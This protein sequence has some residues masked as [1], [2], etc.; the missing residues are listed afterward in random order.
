MT[1]IVIK[2]LNKHSRVVDV[3]F[4][5]QGWQDWARYVIVK[6]KGQNYMKFLQGQP[7]HKNAYDYVTTKLGV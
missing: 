1:E 5:K 3:F 7:L 2:R 6:I 4:G